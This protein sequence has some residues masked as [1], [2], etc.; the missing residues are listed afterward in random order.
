MGILHDRPRPTRAYSIVRAPMSDG[1]GNVI[2]EIEYV[3]TPTGR[4]S[5]DTRRWAQ[6]A[7]PK[8]SRKPRARKASYASHERA[9][10]SR[11]RA[12]GRMDQEGRYPLYD[13]STDYQRYFHA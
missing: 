9:V 13:T 4:V 12:R 3:V 11:I 2:G 6:I 7:S 1:S 5:H 10:R 8:V